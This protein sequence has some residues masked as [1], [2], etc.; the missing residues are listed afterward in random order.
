MEGENPV[1]IDNNGDYTVNC[2]Q[3]PNNKYDL[4]CQWIQA[5]KCVEEMSGNGVA[6]TLYQYR[7]GEQILEPFSYKV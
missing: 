2:L 3:E 6:K 7:S 1:I 5:D 4:Y